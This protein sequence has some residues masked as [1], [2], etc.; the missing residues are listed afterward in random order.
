MIREGA[1]K[2]PNFAGHFTIADWGCGAGCVSIAVIDA[3]DGKVYSGPFQVLSWAMFKYEGRY[4]SNTP[5]FV[6]LDFH[7]DSRLLIARGCPGGSQLRV[8]YFCT[9]G[10]RLEFK[11]I[12]K[13]EKRHPFRS[14]PYANPAL[15]ASTRDRLDQSSSDSPFA[16]ADNM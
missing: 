4:S 2:G 13:V 5:E 8:T 3:K 9:S 14:S 1:A 16:I 15:R 7:P 11:L 6:P 10:R 12:R